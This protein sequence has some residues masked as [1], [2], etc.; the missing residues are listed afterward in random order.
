V[1]ELTVALGEGL[2]RVDE[3]T[4][5]TGFG[6]DARLEVGFDLL[7][8]VGIE[9]GGL[10]TLGIGRMPGDGRRLGLEEISTLGGYLVLF[11][12]SPGGLPRPPRPPRPPRL[13]K[14]LPRPG[15]LRPLKA[16]PGSPVLPQSFNRE[17]AGTTAGG[18][19]LVKVD[20]R[21]GKGAA[22]MG[23]GS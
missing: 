5:N 6:R 21:V 10:E 20:V 18:F 19:V 14:P 17:L 11:E 23:I 13:P 15:L 12:E 16:E 3:S 8:D 2:V 22:I 9:T 7:W 1:D 4:T